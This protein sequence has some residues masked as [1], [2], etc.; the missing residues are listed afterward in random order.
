MR[1]RMLGMNRMD[2]VFARELAV[3]HK[4]LSLY[5]PVGDPVLEDDECGWAQRYFDNGCTVLE[6]GLPNDNPVLDG[7]TVADSMTR[8]LEHVDLG[9]CFGR[10][11]LMRERFPE[12]VLQV[13][14]YYHVMKEMGFEAFADA[15]AE[16][17]VDAV[18]SP[19]VPE[20]EAALLDRL[21]GERG[22]YNL[23]F[24][25]F[26]L[27]DEVIK[28]LC[29]NS[30][31]YIFQQAVD[32]A[33]GARATVSPQVAVNVAR[34]KEAGVSTPVLAG[35]GISNAEQLAEACAMGADGAII[36]SATLTH[37]VQGDADEFLASL[38]VV[39]RGEQVQHG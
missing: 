31:G 4:L 39:C 33:T 12:N 17:G 11:G 20:D 28:D 10:I 21:L 24:A 22:M 34:I 3:G 30:R 35:F 18:L 29:A 25:P 27:T 13:M 37:I 2:A 9:E 23:R 26:V 32:G 14:V 8:A 19:N 6:I 16:S 5:F 36:G 15:C 1:E 7:K 38:G